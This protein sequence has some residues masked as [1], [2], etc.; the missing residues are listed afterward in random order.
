MNK[1]ESFDYAVE[2]VRRTTAHDEKSFM[3]G[4]ERITGKQA[5]IKP[6]AEQLRSGKIGRN[7]QCL[8]GSGDKFKKC[9][10]RNR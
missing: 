3:T 1:P 2:T 6:T 10:G 5:A 4:F 9:C 7:D 8:C